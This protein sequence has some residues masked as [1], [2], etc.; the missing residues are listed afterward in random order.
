MK[1]YF[2]ART[3]E[4]LDLTAPFSLSSW[5]HAHEISD[6]NYPWENSGK[7][8]MK[9]RAMYNR[10][11]LY[12]LYEVEEPQVRVYRNTGAKIEVTMSERVEIFMRKNDKMNPYYCLEIDPTGLVYDYEAKFHREF[13]P[14]WYWPKGHLIIKGEEISQGYRVQCAISLESLRQLELLNGKNIEAGLFRGRCMKEGANADLKWI[15]WVKPDSATPDFHIPSAF[16]MLHL[17]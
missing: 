15:S 11:W 2:V 3:E 12:L 9:F 10:A 16:G 17:E 14:A 4:Q 6:F 8:G 13:N 7:G 5:S 1:K